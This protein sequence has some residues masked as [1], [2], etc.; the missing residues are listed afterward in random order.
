MSLPGKHI[1]GEI[2][3]RRGTII[4]KKADAE[5][6]EFLKKLLEFN[7]FEVLVQENKRRKE[8]EPV[9]YTIGVTDLIFNPTIWIYERRLKTP[10]GKIVTQDYWLQKGENFSPFYWKSKYS[11]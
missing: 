10:E 2:D 5:R 6:V 3:G 11:Q 7:G 1:F 4:E 8:D 9:T